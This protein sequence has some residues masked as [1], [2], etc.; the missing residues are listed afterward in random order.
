MNVL[1]RKLYD[2]SLR[3]AKRK[4]SKYNGFTFREIV[5]FEDAIIEVHSICTKK[6]EE[7]QDMHFATVALDCLKTINDMEKIKGQISMT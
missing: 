5:E 7:T 1:Q 6:F 3:K 4:P 2:A